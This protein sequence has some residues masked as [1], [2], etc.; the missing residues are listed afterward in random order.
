MTVGYSAAV[1]TYRRPE[2][3]REVLRSLLGQH[4]P[5]ELIVVVDNDP[6][7]SAARV[8]AEVARSA[9]IDVLYEP[10]PSNVGP[11]GGWARAVELARVRPDRGHWVTVVDDDDPVGDPRV[12]GRLAACA[13]S[14]PLDVAAVGLRGAL[15]RRRVARLRRVLPQPGGSAPVDY[16]AS[17]GAP[18]YRWD[19]IERVGFFDPELFFG[20]EDLDLGLRLRD[21]GQSLWV[22]DPAGLHE[23]PDSSPTRTAWREYYKTRALVVIARRHLGLGALVST[24]GR[25]LL[26]GMPLLLWGARRLDVV[27]ARWK[28]ARDGLLGRL[29]PASYAPGANPPK[30]HNPA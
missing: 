29:G 25:T 8:V 7:R 6:E 23:V 22:V 30:S 26:L 21:A 12:L 9:T 14:V 18:F 11:A 24:L 16:L 10:L 1:V 15:L 3:L 2:S 28:G 19:A 4:Q 5:P 17:N 27:A 13:A 20:F